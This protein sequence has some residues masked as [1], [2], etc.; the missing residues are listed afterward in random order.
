MRTFQSD[1][2]CVWKTRLRGIS[3]LEIPHF[4]PRPFL[5]GHENTVYGA[6]FSKGTLFALNRTT[7]KL[8]WTRHLGTFSSCVVSVHRRLL[9]TKTSREVFCMDP[10][11]GETN[12]SY[13]PDETD[14]EHIYSRMLFDRSRLYFGDRKGFVYCLSAKD[15]SVIWKEQTNKR[16]KTQVNATPATVGSAIVAVNINGNVCAFNKITGKLFWRTRAAYATLQQ[17]VAYKNNIAILRE[18]KIQVLSLKT[19]KLIKTIKTDKAHL[20]GTLIVRNLFLTV[21]GGTDDETRELRWLNV[22]KG[23]KLVQKL[24]LDDWA[25]G[26]NQVGPHFICIRSFSSFYFYSLKTHQVEYEI[27]FRTPSEI[28]TLPAYENGK[29]YLGDNTNTV[30]CLKLPFSLR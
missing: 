17:P 27:A 18:K 7:G 4:D 16:I 3:H 1:E 14:G 12:W 13:C 10:K 28:P 15:G 8:K 30:Y 24:S 25:R 21:T 26:L 5:L 23:E 11:T 6:T 29:L 22:I 19:G 20:Y 9:Y 2:L